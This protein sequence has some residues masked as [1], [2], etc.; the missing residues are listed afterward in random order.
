MTYDND[1]TIVIPVAQTVEPIAFKNDT[2]PQVDRSIPSLDSS[3]LS[4]NKSFRDTAIPELKAQGYTAGLAQAAVKNRH[5]FPLRYWI[6]DNSGSMNKTD[7]HRILEARKLNKVTFVNCTRWEEIKECVNYHA[8]YAALLGSPTI[9]RLLNAPGSI[10]GPS[11]FSIAEHS[12]DNV[13]SELYEARSLMDRVQPGGYTPLR[14][15]ILKIHD[16]ILPMCDTL[17]ETGQ[18]VVI[19]IATDGRP[20]DESG[21][22]NDFATK[23]FV[24]AMRR[25]EGLPVWVVIRLC[26]DDNDVVEFYN[27]LDENL[28]LSLEVLDDYQG[29]AEE[30]FDMNPWI[31][32][33]LPIHRMRENGFSDRIFDLIDERSLTRSEIRQFCLL[34]FGHDNFE[35]VPDPN[36]DWMGFLNEIDRLNALEQNTYNPITKRVCPYID[37]A[38]LQKK[39]GDGDRCQ[40]TIM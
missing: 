27:N 35:N 7:G 6:I 24:E 23:M 37:T 40:C 17:K 3:R 4:N 9:F 28:E 15:H 20:T 16:L 21:R 18:K 8:N 26:T 19:V 29:E 34:V 38:M 10:V 31:N 36:E 11:S 25:L 1:N 39:H 22:M 30:V 33:A 14:E 12:I 2:P 32:Y 13:N 5:S